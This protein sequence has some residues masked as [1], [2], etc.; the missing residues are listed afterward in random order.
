MVPWRD[1]Y[2]IGLQGEPSTTPCLDLSKL[3]EAG[4]YIEVHVIY[5]DSSRA[6]SY[7]YG[8]ETLSSNS[9]VQRISSVHN[10]TP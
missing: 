3:E 6:D 1:N 5:Y 2:I 9:A 7:L 8:Y 4:R 10:Y